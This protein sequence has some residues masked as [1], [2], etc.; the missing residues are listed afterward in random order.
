MLK[1]DLNIEG[2]IYNITPYVIK[3]SIKEEET[4]F[5]DLQPSTNRLTLLLNKDCPNIDDILNAPNYIN[6][7]LYDDGIGETT[8]INDFYGYLTDNFSWEITDRGKNPLSISAEDYGIKLLKKPWISSNGL[9]TKFTNTPLCN[10]LTPLN[11]LVHIVA[12]LAG[13]TNLDSNIPTIADQINLTVLDDSAIMYWEVLQNILLE[14][15]YIFHFNTSGYLSLYKI[16]KESISSIHTF[17]TSTNIVCERENT[18]IEI[19]KKLKQYKQINITWDEWEQKQGINVFKD[20]TNGTGNYE[21]YIELLPNQY[22]PEGSDSSTYVFTEYKTEN[23]QEIKYVNLAHLDMVADSGIV[24][25]FENIGMK[26]KLRIKN[27]SAVT[28]YIRRLRIVGDEV[29][30]KKSVNISKNGENGQPIFKYSTKY[31]HTSDKVTQFINT[32]KYFYNNSNYSYTF[33]SKDNVS[34]GSIVTLLDSLWMNLNVNVL[35]IKKIIKDNG[36]IEYSCI[37]IDEFNLDDNVDRTITLPAPGTVTGPAGPEGPQGLD[38]DVIIESDNGSV[39]KI[40]QTTHI[41]LI[42]RVFL[43]G[44]EITSTIPESR[45]SW[46]RS[47]YYPRIYPDDDETW[48]SNHT[49]GYKTIEITATDIYARATYFCD[50]I[51]LY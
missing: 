47:S 23:G 3:Y 5:N 9:Y 6:V 20:T 36:I 45:F 33:K 29:V 27:T 26:G 17:S 2:I 16:A 48:N 51:N 31:I 10:K 34:I 49:A 4:L 21:C 19:K 42:A 11:S 32:I 7:F 12:G 30:L 50:I 41:T 13:V 24:A 18:G 14:Y 1:V 15:G 37:G 35:I 40:G 28:A 39:F 44:V 38:Y 8:V 25:E 46:R 43:N 22:Y